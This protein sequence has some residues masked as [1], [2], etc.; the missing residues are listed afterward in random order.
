M[1]EL[2][3]AQHQKAGE[4]VSQ[5]LVDLFAKHGVTLRHAFLTGSRA[6]GWPAT[7]SDFDICVHQEGMKAAAEVME[8][9][10]SEEIEESE[11]N[12][13]KKGNVPPFGMVN[14]IPLHPLDMLCWY[15]AT[16]EIKRTAVLP[17]VASRLGSREQ[18]HGLFES[19]RGFYKTCIPYEGAEKT[20]Q[21]LARVQRRDQKIREALNKEET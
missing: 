20:L 10:A 19:L 9:L 11:Y 8:K 4:S 17:G 5:V 2:T 3:T 13:G 15:L 6:F 16:Q 18:K 14:L 7:D 21:T 12:A 1:P